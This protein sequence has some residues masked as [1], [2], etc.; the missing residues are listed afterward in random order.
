MQSLVFDALTQPLFAFA[1]MDLMTSKLW[2]D[3]QDTGH[4][5]VE[6]EQPSKKKNTKNQNVYTEILIF[7]GTA[8]RKDNNNNCTNSFDLFKLSLNLTHVK[9]WLT[10]TCTQFLLGSGALL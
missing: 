4:Y 6:I 10:P 9:L 7:I 2:T 8:K 1:E 5:K 3:I